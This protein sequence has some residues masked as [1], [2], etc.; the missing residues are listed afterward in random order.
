MHRLGKES[1]KCPLLENAPFGIPKGQVSPKSH[2]SY[3]GT[4]ASLESQTVLSFAPFL[5]QTVLFLFRYFVF[6]NGAFLTTA[7]ARSVYKIR[8]Q[9]H[10]TRERCINTIY[11]LYCSFSI[12][13]A[14]G[15]NHGHSCPV[16]AKTFK[17]TRL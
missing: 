5:S 17:F 13:Q 9:L 11:I 15:Y 7:L 14:S 10:E 2:Y 8:N 1:S 12:C 6:P 4:F 3:W 16:V